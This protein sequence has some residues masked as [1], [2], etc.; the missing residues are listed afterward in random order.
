MFAC[1]CILKRVESTRAQGSENSRGSPPYHA[2]PRIEFKLSGLVTS[3]LPTGPSHQPYRKYFIILV[4]LQMELRPVR[5]PSKHCTKTYLFFYLKIIF[6]YVYVC[7]GMG[8]QSPQR[9]KEG[10][11]SPGATNS[12][13]SQYRC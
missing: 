12:C 9:P 1:I 3:F 7:I 5:I 8:K 2:N 10:A 4:V 6:T 11:E 13:E